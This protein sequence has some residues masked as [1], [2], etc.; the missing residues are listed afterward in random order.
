MSAE[1]R[2]FLTGTIALDVMLVAALLLTLARREVPAERGPWR[3][4][5][6]VLAIAIGVQ[7]V[8]FLEE[9]ATGFHHR[10]PE[11]LG[12]V[13]W[14]ASLW[15]SF[16]LAWIAIWGLALAGLLAG[17]RSALFPVWFLAVACV[18]NG[19]AHPL[20]AL[21]AGGYFPGLWTSPLAGLVGGVLCARLA[22]FTGPAAAGEPAPT[23]QAGLR[24][25]ILSE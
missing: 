17:R 8:H 21:A 22:S 6:L 14:S 12:L 15:V 3:R 5:A 9:W 20:L 16:N 2:S 18:A 1:L 11:L 24:K 25:G 7:G 19:V 13:P 23:V 10:F 4:L